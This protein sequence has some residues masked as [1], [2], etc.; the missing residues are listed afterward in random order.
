MDGR[1]QSMG[2]GNGRKD[3]LMNNDIR[4]FAQKQKRDCPCLIKCLFYKFISIQ[5]A[6][7]QIY[8]IH[9]AHGVIGKTL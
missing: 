4:T 1:Q 9:I 6:N 3:S 7:Y 8:T 2:E 5:K